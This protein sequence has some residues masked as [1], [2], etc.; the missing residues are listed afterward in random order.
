M[1]KRFRAALENIQKTWLWYFVIPVLV[2]LLVEVYFV[3][4]NVMELKGAQQKAELASDKE[5]M[6]AEL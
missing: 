6:M 4:K 3:V 1:K 5:Q 2:F